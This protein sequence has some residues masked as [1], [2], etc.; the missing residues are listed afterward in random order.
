M[1]STGAPVEAAN[2]RVDRR[3]AEFFERYITGAKPTGDLVDAQSMLLPMEWG[4]HSGGLSFQMIGAGAL[5]HIK[6]LMPGMP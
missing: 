2:T 5:M 3:K 4:A 1:G 6:M